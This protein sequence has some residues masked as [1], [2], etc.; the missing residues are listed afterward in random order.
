MLPKGEFLT[1]PVTRNWWR[2]WA[3]FWTPRD[4][5]I[6][7]YLSSLVR[8]FPFQ[9]KWICQVG[10]CSLELRCLGSQEDMSISKDHHLHQRLFIL[11]NPIEITGIKNILFQVAVASIFLAARW[12]Y[13]SRFLINTPP[14][15]LDSTLR[16]DL[17]TTLQ[18]RSP[19]ATVANLTLLMPRSLIKFLVPST[20]SIPSILSL[21][22]ARN[23]TPHLW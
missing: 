6:I 9:I 16:L 7:T 11:Q 19:S 13:T 12:S 8:E 5:P 20:I 18:T 17:R 3:H 1:A 23:K 21:I 2:Q 22:R 4:Q 15:V 14:S 10:E